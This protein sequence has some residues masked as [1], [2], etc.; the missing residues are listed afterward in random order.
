M[1]SSSTD[2]STTWAFLRSKAIIGT[3]KQQIQGGHAH[4]DAGV[5]L[6]EDDGA[7]GVVGHEAVQFHA[8]VDGARVAHAGIGLQKLVALLGEAVQQV[9]LAQVR[10][11]RALEALALDAQHVHHVQ[12]RQRLV[13]S[14]QM[15]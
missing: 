7:L 4:E 1:P 9:V 13:F 8:A 5:N 12:L 14:S 15:E 3:S 2:G 10:I 11:G 6:V